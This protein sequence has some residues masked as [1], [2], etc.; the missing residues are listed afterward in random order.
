MGTKAQESVWGG[1]LRNEIWGIAD[2]E[3]TAGRSLEKDR[4]QSE[5]R[6]LPSRSK[7]GWPRC[8][9]WGQGS[10]YKIT[11]A[12]VWTTYSHTMQL[13]E[14]VGRRDEIRAGPSSLMSPGPDS[15]LYLD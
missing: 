15:F 5:K 9:G 2:P 8:A 3:W 7:P 12:D 4:I 6:V 10:D 11:R 1:A 13:V 14:R